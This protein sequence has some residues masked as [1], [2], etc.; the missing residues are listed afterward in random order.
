MAMGLSVHLPE[1]GEVVLDAGEQERVEQLAEEEERRRVGALVVRVLPARVRRSRLDPRPQ[2]DHQHAAR[3]QPQRRRDGR[4]LP[5]AAVRVHA[6]GDA[7]RGK[8][9]R[10]RGGGERVLRGEPHLRPVHR[11]V[12][13]VQQAFLG[14]L[15]EDLGVAGLDVGRRERDAEDAPVGDALVQVAPGDRP[16]HQ[17]RQRS[18]VE[19]AARSALAPGAG[20]PAHQ[21][22]Q[23]APAQLEDG[24]EAERAPLLG[25]EP[26]AQV[27]RIVQA[28]MA[29]TL[30]PQKM[31]G[32]ACS[33]SP[34]ERLP[35]MYLRTPTS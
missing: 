28:L 16:A 30:V 26:D 4:V 6:A 27:R 13:R 11:A 14:R 31:R 34:A 19:Q 23:V 15:D 17:L 20:D 33:P 35:R 21:A 29:P 12:A 18:G 8:D 7:H 5:E 9:D 32:R 22:G 1:V 2:P 24:V 3:T 25:E 10:N